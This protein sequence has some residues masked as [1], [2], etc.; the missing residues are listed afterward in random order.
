MAP[1]ARARG[2][3]SHGGA[4]V[5][6]RLLLR[7]GGSLGPPASCRP[8]TA[9]LRRPATTALWSAADAHGAGRVSG[10]TKFAITHWRLNELGHLFP[11]KEICRSETT[12]ILYKNL[13]WI[14]N[15]VII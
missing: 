3:R 1:A 13:R 11:D 6:V 9:G 7:V 12:R 10:V 4:A 8:P 15:K 5:R 14:F 2:D